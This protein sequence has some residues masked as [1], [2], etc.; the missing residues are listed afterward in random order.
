MKVLRV[1][2]KASVFILA[3]GFALSLLL[4]GTAGAVEYSSEVFDTVELQDVIVTARRRPERAIDVP[5]A[6][7]VVTGSELDSRR[8]YQLE[9]LN[10]IS[11]SL[12][13]SYFNPRGS[14]V[15]IRGVGHSP[16]SDGLEASVGIFVDGVYLGRPGMAVYDLTDI[17]DIE[18]LRGPQG[19][20]F[21]KNT[22]AGAI[23]ITTRRPSFVPE[24]DV[25]VSLGTSGYTQIRASGSGAILGEKVAGRLSVYSTRYAGRVR[26][27][28]TGVRFNDSDRSGA[29]IQFLLKPSA[30]FQIR[31]IGEYNTEDDN[32]C[33]LV[34]GSFGAPSSTYLSRV[35]LAGGTAVL[36]GDRYAT[37]ANAPT[38]VVVRQ[39]GVTANMVYYFGGVELTS[40]TGYRFWNYRSVFDGDLSSADAYDSAAVPTDA[41]QFSQEFRLANQSG[42]QVDWLGGLYYFR[43]TLK[44]DL[45]LAFGGQ[46]ANFL[47]NTATP[48][49][50]LTAFNGVTSSTRSALDSESAA[51]FGH[52]TWR[53]SRRLDL[54]FGMRATYERRSGVVDRT[55]NAA[56]AAYHQA[57]SV[58]NF[59]PSGTLSLSFAPVSGVR[60]YAGYARGTK[61]GGVNP[62]VS[63]VPGDLIVRPEQTDSYEIGMKSLLL[64]GRLQTSASLFLAKIDNYQAS[65]NRLFG[66]I[67]TNVGAASTR[68]VELQVRWQPTRQLQISSSASYND[69]RYDSY[70]N[71][72]CAPEKPAAISCDLTGRP[73][74]NA[75]R[76]IGSLSV[77]YSRNISS[78]VMMGVGADY[79]YRSSYY[80]NLDNSIYSILGDVG[81]ANVRASVEFT[82]PN[83]NAQLWVKNI[84]DVR[85]LESY[86]IGGSTIYGAYFG[87]IGAGRTMGLTVAQSF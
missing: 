40:V 34:A 58:E 74:S 63:A 5:V 59:D 44:S 53:L 46:A 20:L 42:G 9:D 57:V 51:A 67:L 2:I 28:S 84:A 24:A 8:L 79:S 60:L 3:S 83:I 54:T 65:Y 80:G 38:Q 10:Q 39:G 25:E 6:L 87:A 4:S 35:A 21:G 12:N 55:M 85:Y 26:N 69:A 14:Y 29:R 41:R 22:S 27:D 64:E 56:Q 48:P 50:F 49:S 52:A 7:S 1:D 17:E 77:D 66:A 33:L 47:G 75:P 30:D 23:S 72:P 70:L 36:G 15:S 68:G 45:I 71:A 31:I 37:T 16:A 78:F 13:V 18:I 81:I 32:C 11:P 82:K 61:A 73:L 43:Q 62:T 86:P 19:T 76:W